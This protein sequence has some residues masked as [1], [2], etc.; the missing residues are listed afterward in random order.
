M[1][2]GIDISRWQNIVSTP[3][4]MDFHKAREQGA[5]FVF[6]KASQACWMD[7]DF[8]MNWDNAR[9]AG[10][11]RGAYHYMDWTRPAVE[12]AN[13]FWGVLQ[14]DRGELPPVLDY[15]CRVNPLD[16]GKMRQYCI[17]FLRQIE[18]KIGRPPIL[19]TSPGYWAQ[20]G[21]PDVAWLKFPLWLAHYYTNTPRVPLPWKAYTFWQYT[22]VGDGLAYG[23]ESKELDLDWY[24]GTREQ[25]FTFA[26]INEVP[27]PEIPPALDKLARLDEIDRVIKYVLNRRKEVEEGT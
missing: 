10:L 11:L 22:D 8:T 4:Y 9:R 17:D 21:S 14:A 26:G 24:N 13:F 6:I 18:S 16:A 12:Q 15:E 7:R 3:Q 20:Y 2:L 1:I 23:A 5:Q 25:L 19:Y 27:L